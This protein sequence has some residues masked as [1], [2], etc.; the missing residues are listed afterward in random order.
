[1]QAAREA[2]RRQALVAPPQPG[3]RRARP[4]SAPAAHRQQV[5]TGRQGD[6]REVAVAEPLAFH[7]DVDRRWMSPESTATRTNSV[8]NSNAVHPGRY[9]SAA[10]GGLGLS[11]ENAMIGKIRDLQRTNRLIPALHGRDPDHTGTIDAESFHQC[12]Y[13]LE[14]RLS[15]PQV[16]RIFSSLGVDGSTAAGRMDYDKFCTKL[17]ADVRVGAAKNAYETHSH[18]DMWIF[19]KEEESPANPLA[20]VERKV[21]TMLPRQGADPGKA[22]S[23]FNLTPAPPGPVYYTAQTAPWSGDVSVMGQLLRPPESAAQTLKAN[24]EFWERSKMAWVVAHTDK[25]RNATRR[26][27]LA[28]RENCSIHDAHNEERKAA[29]LSF[30]AQTQAKRAMK[31]RFRHE[32]YA[33][34]ARALN[35]S[36]LYRKYEGVRTDR[37]TKYHTIDP[38]Q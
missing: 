1:M 9:A 14:V 35:V 28:Q 36:N 4:Q 7:E 27:R 33:A 11:E 29:E 34:K 6:M 19:R 30:T 2:S 17:R 31:E 10:A 5:A 20:R 8:H 16:Q 23:Q 12:M 26:L 21:V 38:T 3:Y 13:E 25:D 18:S 32:V 22:V 37:P 24:R 15:L